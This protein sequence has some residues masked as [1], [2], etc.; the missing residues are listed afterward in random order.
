MESF[1]RLSRPLQLL[2][3]I[4]AAYLAARIAGTLVAA[5]LVP[6]PAL[7]APAAAAPLPEP[8][9]LDAG[10]ASQLLQLPEARPAPLPAALPGGWN[11]EPVR[12][13]LR[14]LVEGTAVTEPARY[15]LCL[16]Q[17]PDRAE[18]RVY[19]LGETYQGARIYGIERGRVLLDNAGH[20]EFLDGGGAPG[21]AQ[22]LRAQADDLREVSP[23]RYALTRAA[24]NQK[25]G[26]MNELLTQARVMP[27]CKSPGACEGFRFASIAPGSLYASLGLQGGDV[28]RRINGY[29]LTSP[30]KALELF[31]KL[32]DASRIELDLERSG[33]PVRKVVSI[34]P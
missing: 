15:S 6:A 4:F 27:S 14:G 11:V 20:N 8:A 13:A 18:S 2:A 7:A 3:W 12:S 9:R 22:P 10:K 33:Q 5:R 29:E 19:V 31:Q 32:R 25:L 23:N 21:S 17:D 1:L 26:N 30:E 16:L 24:L 34:E 28:V